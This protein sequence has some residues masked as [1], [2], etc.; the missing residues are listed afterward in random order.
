MALLLRLMLVLSLFICIVGG[1]GIHWRYIAI[2]MLLV[3][4]W[5][6]VACWWRIFSEEPDNKLLHRRLAWGATAI[7]FISCGQIATT[8]VDNSRANRELNYMPLDSSRSARRHQ[9]YR[10]LCKTSTRAPRRTK[11]VKLTLRSKSRRYF[12]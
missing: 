6:K 1:T 12:E 5:C 11:I 3:A 7:L 9:R 8:Y 10:E 2:T 4:M